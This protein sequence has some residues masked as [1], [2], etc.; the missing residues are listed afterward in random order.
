MPGPGTREKR[1]P[2]RRLAP[3]ARRALI[4]EAATRVFAEV[5]YEAATMQA[6]A[7]AAGVVASVIYDHFGSKQELYVELIEQHGRAL[8]AGTIRVPSSSDLGGELRRRIEDYFRMIEEDPFVWRL[9]LRDPPGNPEIAAIHARVHAS[10]AQ[11]IAGVLA[12]GRAADEG[13]EAGSAA[14]IEAIL[15][16]EMIKSSLRG[17]A[18]WWWQH[19]DVE[20]EVLV[21]TATSVLW[22]GLSRAGP[23]L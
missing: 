8:I 22:E 5:G 15:V 21:E 18:E 10:A 14:S 12:G 20:R 16:G 23:K 13:M 4:E 2:R 17:L 6:I 9:L 3:P 7:E 11:G 19:R 1:P